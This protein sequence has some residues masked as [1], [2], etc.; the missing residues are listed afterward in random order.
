MVK[1]ALLGLLRE[2]AD[3]G[4]SLKLRFEEYLGSVWR[5]NTGQV[6]QTLRR[7]TRSGLVV[8]LEIDE[9]ENENDP[10]RLRRRFQLTA[11]GSRVLERWLQRPSLKLI[12]AR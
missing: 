2:Q 12:P 6:Y 9:P 5:L 8:E 10:H 7:L 1:Y 11:K 3:Y 4:Y